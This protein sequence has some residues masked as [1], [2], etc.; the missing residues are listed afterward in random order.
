MKKRIITLLLSFLLVVPICISFTACGHKHQFASEWESDNT[1]H[2]HSSTCRHKDKVYGKAEH[3]YTNAQLLYYTENDEVY[4]VRNCIVCGRVSPRQKVSNAT[5]VKSTES[6][7][8]ALDNLSSNKTI[9]FTDG[10]YGHLMFKSTVGQILSN[11]TLVGSNNA[12]VRFLELSTLQDYAPK[13]LTIENLSFVNNDNTLSGGISTQIPVENLTINNCHFEGNSNVTMGKYSKDITITNCTFKNIENEN[14]L[15]AIVLNDSDCVKIISNS[16]NGV[17]YNGIQ[18]NKLALNSTIKIEENLFTRINSRFIDC[19]NEEARGQVNI[20]AN[21]FY[22]T[23]PESPNYKEDGHY[24]NS[25]GTPVSVGVNTWEEVPQLN[26]V[27][28]N[29]ATYNP[30]EQKSL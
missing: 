2:W 9:Y 5:V 29:G 8:E 11:I 14:N 24:I 27:D 18:T 26:S 23:N 1:H 7:Q 12:N 6:A 3:D 20:L 15:S 4:Y 25:K 28:I 13:N 16:F 10:N 30:N 19:T 21:T 17:Q 22:K